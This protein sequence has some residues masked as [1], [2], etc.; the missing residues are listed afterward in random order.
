MKGRL[1][2]RMISAGIFSQ[3]RGNIRAGEQKARNLSA[4]CSVQLERLLNCMWQK[5]K[6]GRTHPSAA[7]A[8]LVLNVL[9]HG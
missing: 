8:A 7:K 1:D 2:G 4:L 5:S 6:S 3:P 9:R